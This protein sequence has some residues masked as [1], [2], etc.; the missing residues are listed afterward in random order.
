MDVEFKSK[1]DSPQE[2]QLSGFGGL[3]RAWVEGGGHEIA[4]L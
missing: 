4:A 3:I 2:L 1:L